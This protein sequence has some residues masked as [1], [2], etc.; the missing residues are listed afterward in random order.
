MLT[1]L[2]VTTKSFYERCHKES[3]AQFYDLAES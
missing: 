1:R 2:R 3:M